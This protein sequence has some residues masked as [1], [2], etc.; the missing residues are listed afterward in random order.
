[1][2]ALYSGMHIHGL[3]FVLLPS[4]DLARAEAFYR[5]VLGLELD[6]RWRDMGIEFKLEGDLTL[7][8]AD[9][10]KIGQT[11]A[12]MQTATVALKT[13]DFE[14]SKA[15]LEAKGVEFRDVIDSGVCKMAFFRD[16]DGNY[17]MLHHR[18][19]P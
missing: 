1:V 10:A 8:L 5:D 6:C 12:P 13:N 9:S 2:L 17:L 15:A 7:G 19:A 4:Q 11:F 14:G 18:Y 3:D 16:P